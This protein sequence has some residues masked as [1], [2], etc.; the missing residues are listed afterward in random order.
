MNDPNLLWGLI[1]LGIALL[2]LMVEIFV[3][4]MGVITFTSGVVAIVGIVLLFRVSAAWGITGLLTM[5][6]LGPIVVMFGLQVLPH[7]TMGKKL[8]YGE[9]GKAEVAVRDDP[10]GAEALA[11][12]IGAEGV[13]LVDLRPMGVI[14]VGDRKLDAVSEISFVRAGARV[15]VTAADGMTIRVRPVEGGGGAPGAPGAPGAAS[16]PP[17]A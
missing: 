2:L 3:P 6:V 14:K 11:R 1:L 17:V 7:T 8:L 5:M 10:E 9:T 13:V 4:S 12:L 16:G 15:R